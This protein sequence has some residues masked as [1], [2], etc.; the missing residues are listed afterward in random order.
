VAKDSYFKVNKVR[1]FEF[2]VQP[3]D[4]LPTELNSRKYHNIIISND[5]ESE[6]HVMIFYITTFLLN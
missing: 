1:N 4:F 6:I 5:M 3:T 2:E